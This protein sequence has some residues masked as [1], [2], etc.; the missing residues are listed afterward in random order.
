MTRFMEAAKNAELTVNSSI[1]QTRFMIDFSST[2]LLAVLSAL[3]I[4]LRMIDH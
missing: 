3:L 2:I 1:I 4:V